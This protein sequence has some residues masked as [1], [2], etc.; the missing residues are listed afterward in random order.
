MKVIEK[1]FPGFLMT[2]GIPE[3]DFDPHERRAAHQ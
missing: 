2:A 3:P 1:E